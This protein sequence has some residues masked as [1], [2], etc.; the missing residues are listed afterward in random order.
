MDNID[1]VEANKDC[2]VQG[3]DEEIYRRLYEQLKLET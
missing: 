2:Y 3:N 1:N